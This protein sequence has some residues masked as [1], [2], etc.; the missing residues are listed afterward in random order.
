MISKQIGHKE[1]MEKSARRGTTLSRT[2]TDFIPG[3][4]WYW[5]WYDKSKI[6]GEL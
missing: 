6:N 3:T 1:G 5:E 4:R 2:I